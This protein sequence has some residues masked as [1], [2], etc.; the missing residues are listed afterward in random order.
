MQRR[1]ESVRNTLSKMLLI[2]LAKKKVQNTQINLKGYQ[3][4]RVHGNSKARHSIQANTEVVSIQGFLCTG[5]DCMRWAAGEFNQENETRCV[6]W[7]GEMWDRRMMRQTV[8]DLTWLA[9]E[10]EIKNSDQVC[11]SKWSHGFVSPLRWQ[12]QRQTFSFI[13]HKEII[14]IWMKH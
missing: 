8:T 2:W 9:Q 3:D 4:Y 11:K 12:K 1:K 14:Y 5:L 13:W 7:E 6:E 10:N